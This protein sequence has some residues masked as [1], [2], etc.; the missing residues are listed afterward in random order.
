MGIPTGYYAAPG[1]A[2][3]Y[4]YAPMPAA[5][6]GAY[7]GYG[8]HYPAPGGGTYFAGMPGGGAPPAGGGV[9]PA[10]GAVAGGAPDAPHGGMYYAP[11]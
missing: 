7:A 5:G 8:I 4:A 1:G 3:G 9:A 6:G 10:G 2:P 11:A